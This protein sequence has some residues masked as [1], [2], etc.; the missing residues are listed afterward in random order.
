MVN[1]THDADLHPALQ[2]IL[3]DSNHEPIE[4]PRPRT[5]SLPG[6]RIRNYLNRNA[7]VQQGVI[8]THR[9]RRLPIPWLARPPTPTPVDSSES[10][11]SPIHPTPR[12]FL[13]R[14]QIILRQTVER[15]KQILQ[16]RLHRPDP[17]P[18]NNQN[19]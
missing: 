9:R 19:T 3:N 13:S 14:A 8:I 4:P 10:D 2:L 11:V 12:S 17:P 16:T 1:L 18:E 15:I 6:Q 5:L 7:T